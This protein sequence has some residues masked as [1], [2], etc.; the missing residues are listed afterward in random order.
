MFNRKWDLTLHVVTIT[1]TIYKD[2]YNLLFGGADMERAMFF[3]NH[4]PEG[5]NKEEF[6][7]IAKWVLDKELDA[8]VV[9]VV[10]ALLGEN[11]DGNLSLDELSP[12]M[13][14][15]RASKGFDKVSVNVGLGG[16]ELL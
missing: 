16:Y 15:W 4:D 7:A 14:Q 10:F 9:D 11:R 12:V 5:V 13:F 3:L 1:C 2:F 6:S 8:H